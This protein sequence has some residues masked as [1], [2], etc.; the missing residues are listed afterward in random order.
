[1]T[2]EQWNSHTKAPA[3]AALCRY[4]SLVIPRPWVIVNCRSCRSWSA[5]PVNAFTL[6]ALT[7]I[8]I[9]KGQ[10][11]IATYRKSDLSH[12]QFCRLCGGHLMTIHPPLNIVD[13]F[14]ATRLPDGAPDVR[15]SG[16]ECSGA[17]APAPSVRNSFLTAELKSCQRR[18]SLVCNYIPGD[19]ISRHSNRRTNMW[20]KALQQWLERK[21]FISDEQRAEV[22]QT[23][24]ERH[25]L[26]LRKS[27]VV[28][29]FFPPPC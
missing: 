26:E 3:S 2:G 5:G 20:F 6:W 27:E 14:A 17:W 23:E 18:E 19:R 24:Q 15:L 25:E 13:V 16:D 10:K 7:A 9:S 1:M 11:H 22:L 8:T 29:W 21:T 28:L 12:R 4:R